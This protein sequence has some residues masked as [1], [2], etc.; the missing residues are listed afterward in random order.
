MIILFCEE[1]SDDEPQVQTAMNCHGPF[2]RAK[3][4]ELLY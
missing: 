4:E 3:D 2:G 1:L